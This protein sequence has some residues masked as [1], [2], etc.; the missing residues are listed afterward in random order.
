MMGKMFLPYALSMPSL[1]SGTGRHRR[2]FQVEPFWTRDREEA[3]PSIVMSS[4]VKSDGGSKVVDD[5][6]D[7]VE[8]FDCQ[9]AGI[10]RVVDQLE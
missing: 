7:V 1:P 8:S 2:A 6:A 3:L 10:A 9:V 5:D 4:A